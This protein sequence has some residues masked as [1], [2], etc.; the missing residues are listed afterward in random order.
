M[1]LEPGKREQVQPFHKPCLPY[2]LHLQPSPPIPKQNYNTLFAPTPLPTYPY[3]RCPFKSNPPTHRQA[4]PSQPLPQVKLL[5]NYW[6][7][8]VGSTC[9]I[10][11]THFTHTE[12]QIPWAGETRLRFHWGPD[13]DSTGNGDQTQIPRVVGTRLRIFGSG[14]QIQIPRVVGTRL[15][16]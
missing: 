12:T 11:E 3:A 8:L 10:L 2:T 7:S 6:R 14:D 9:W 13:T 16:F 1:P 4:P 5:F 15:R